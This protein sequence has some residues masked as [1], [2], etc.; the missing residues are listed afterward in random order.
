MTKLKITSLFF[1]GAKVRKAVDAAR[2]KV[3]SKAGALL[4]TIARNSLRPAPY[5]KRSSPG[6]PP[7]DHTG[8]TRRQL[9][10]RRKAAG[11]SRIKG[12]FTGLRYILFGYNPDT[13]SVIVG[14]ASNRSQP[15]KIPEK[16]E[17][18]GSG[19]WHGKQV[20]IGPRPF[21]RPALNR[22]S[23]ELPKR[24]AGQVRAT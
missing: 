12:G 10:K 8:Y 22:V 13:E 7:L 14:P 16:L 6:Q 19:K 1:D 24:W 20:Q 21:M 3:L 5:G 18:G 17:F 2:R 11:Q 4:R 9:N 15:H 23:P